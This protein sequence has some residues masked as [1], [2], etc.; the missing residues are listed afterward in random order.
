MRSSVHH[1]WV[2]RMIYSSIAH[3]ARDRVF[4]Q[5]PFLCAF[6]AGREQLHRDSVVAGLCAEDRLH[7]VLATSLGL[8]HY[9]EF[10]QSQML[11]LLAN[12]TVVLLGDSIT[13]R[14]FA[15][16]VCI[17]ETGAPCDT[18]CV[19]TVET[20]GTRVPTERRTGSSCSPWPSLIKSNAS[21]TCSPW[22][23]FSAGAYSSADAHR[24]ACRYEQLEHGIKIIFYF[25]QRAWAHWSVQTFGSSLC[26]VICSSTSLEP[27]RPSCI[28]GQHFT[29]IKSSGTLLT[30]QFAICTRVLVGTSPALG[31]LVSPNWSHARLHLE[32]PSS[33][34]LGCGITGLMSWSRACP[35][36]R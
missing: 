15:H 10:T 20:V 22:T 9:C 14:I 19:E 30:P 34:T 25:I 32:M 33:P 21:M 12:R 36:S 26:L 28:L 24:N 5:R 1:A 6:A 3:L 23:N 31:A 29:L 18:P 35:R 7:P 16:F 11:Q 17:V 4:M 27:W 13:R 2:C 8:S